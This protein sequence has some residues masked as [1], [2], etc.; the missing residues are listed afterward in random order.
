MMRVVAGKRYN[1][2]TAEEV[3]KVDQRSAGEQFWFVERLYRTA[4]G[5]HFILGIGG[6]LSRWRGE[7]GIVPLDK[8]QV[9]HWYRKHTRKEVQ[10]VVRYGKDHEPVRQPDDRGDRGTGNEAAVQPEGAA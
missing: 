2:K 10:R 8:E 9:D 3:A 4:S 6:D 5:D 7:S 1:T